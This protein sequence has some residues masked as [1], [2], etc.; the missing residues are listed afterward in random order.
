MVNKE[1]NIT[2]VDE[3]DRAFISNFQT[4]SAEMKSFVQGIV[5]TAKLLEEKI[6]STKAQ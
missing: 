6:A 2:N 1:Q 3:F 5:V 4:L